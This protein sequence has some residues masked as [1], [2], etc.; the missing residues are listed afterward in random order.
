MYQ[1]CTVLQYLHIYYYG[2]FIFT[3][4]VLPGTILFLSVKKK[5]KRKTLQ[6]GASSNRRPGA[7]PG[8]GASGVQAAPLL[9]VREEG[10]GEALGREVRSGSCHT[11]PCR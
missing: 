3:V 4:I 11:V 9:D 10:S 1:Y 2:V 5:K 7:Y 6:T 8:A